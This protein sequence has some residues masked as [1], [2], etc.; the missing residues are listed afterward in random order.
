MPFNVKTNPKTNITKPITQL[1]HLSN[2][3]NILIFSIIP[4]NVILK[5]FWDPGI[6]LFGKIT[7][8]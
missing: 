3:P 7:Y 1:T 4:T 6:F 5:T 8:Y 2:L